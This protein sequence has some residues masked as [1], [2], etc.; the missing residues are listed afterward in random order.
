MNLL[1]CL[2]TPTISNVWGKSIPNKQ[3]A[4]YYRDNGADILAVA[5]LD[6]VLWSSPRKKGKIV[7]CPQLDDRLGV[8]VIL[9]V[10]PRLGVNVDVLLTDCEEVG[11]ST[12][13]FFHPE[14]QYNWMVEFDRKGTDVVM[15]DYD[16]EEY[17]DML[18]E[19]N[20]SPAWGSWSDICHLDHLDIAGF[21]IGTG[22]HNE[23]THGCYADLNDTL[24][25]AELFADFWRDHRKELLPAPID[26][27]EDEY[28]Y[29]DDD[30]WW[31]IEQRA[32]YYGY[33]NTNDFILEGGLQLLG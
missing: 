12:A 30:G 9:N 33:D 26:V 24:S 23:H 18:W 32:R 15:Y 14:K 13:D 31:A 27:V 25:Q 11:R 19:A 3:G 7:R 29:E 6:S 22:Y 5:H 2:T 10:L 21:N 20:F 1:D 28:A 17:A 8:W 4:L 16:C